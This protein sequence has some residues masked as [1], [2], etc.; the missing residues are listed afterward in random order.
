MTTKERLERVAQL[1]A[2][3][4]IGFLR[5]QSLHAAAVDW[6]RLTAPNAASFD[7]PNRQCIECGCTDDHACPGGCYWVS[8]E[9]P[10]CS[11]CA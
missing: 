1:E 4:S 6:R 5:S 11:A 10:I 2:Q 8:L 7:D 9:P 3:Y